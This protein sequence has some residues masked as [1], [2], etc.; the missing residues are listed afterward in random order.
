MRKMKIKV[1]MMDISSLMEEEKKDEFQR[2]C[3]TLSEKRQ[4][5]IEKFDNLC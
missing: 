5:K 1:Y 4:K 2:L 3:A